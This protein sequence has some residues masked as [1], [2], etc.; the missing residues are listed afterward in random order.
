MHTGGFVQV[1]GEGLGEHR[2]RVPHQ[3]RRRRDQQGGEEDVEGESEALADVRDAHGERLGQR[4][5]ER[6]EQRVQPDSRLHPA[7]EAQKPGGLAE[8]AGPFD[9]LPRDAPE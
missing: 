5:Q 3:D 1:R 8:H 4:E 7:V 9:E 6:E 2:D